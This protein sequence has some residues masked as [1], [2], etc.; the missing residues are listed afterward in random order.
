V[1]DDRLRR[2]V[3]FSCRNLLDGCRELG[4]FDV[5]FLR[6]VLIY[7]DLETRRRVLE[8][9]AAMLPDDGYLVLGGTETVLGVTGAL[10][11]VPEAR[12]VFRP[13]RGDPAAATATGAGRWSPA[14]MGLT[15]A[16]APGTLGAGMHHGGAASRG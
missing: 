5:I 14:A 2:I 11:A 12:G 13:A 7:F 15:A 4:Q 9:V 1:I 16:P 10:T 6:N 8:E 3:A